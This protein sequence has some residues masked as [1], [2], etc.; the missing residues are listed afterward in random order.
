M[1]FRRYG[2]GAEER[3]RKEKPRPRADRWQM[4]AMHTS[5]SRRLSW[6]VKLSS[7]AQKHVQANRGWFTVVAG[8][9]T[10]DHHAW[11]FSVAGTHV[12]VAGCATGAA[13]AQNTMRPRNG[14]RRKNNG[15]GH[16]ASFDKAICKRQR[17]RTVPLLGLIYGLVLG[18][19]HTVAVLG[20]KGHDD[21][22]SKALIAA[23]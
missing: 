23:A 5:T 18:Y 1:V 13:K 17:S 19:S 4:P 12:M 10:F 20:G 3:S 15:L 6:G 7:L 8:A 2:E 11:K 16:T 22:K 9:G 21:A 14:V